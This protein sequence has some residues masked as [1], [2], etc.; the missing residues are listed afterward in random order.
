MPAIQYRA[1]R[2]HFTSLGC[3]LIFTL[4]RISLAHAAQSSC[5]VYNFAD[6]HAPCS[7]HDTS[8]EAAVNDVIACDGPY[9][10]PGSSDTLD[11]VDQDPR[12]AGQTFVVTVTFTAGPSCGVT[13]TGQ[14]TGSISAASGPACP[15]Q[16]YYVSTEPP[17]TPQCGCKASGEPVDG[18]HDP[19]NPAT[20]DVFETEDD[21]VVT[22]P[23]GLRFQRLY[24]S[25]VRGTSDL[26]P[27]WRH[28]YS[29]SLHFLTGPQYIPYPPGGDTLFPVCDLGSRVY[30]GV[31][32]DSELRACM[33]D[34]EC[35]M[36]RFCLRAAV[37][38]RNGGFTAGSLERGL[39]PDRR[40]DDGSRCGSR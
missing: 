23:G 30:F 3:L 12:V 6:P 22:G 8:A 21:V 34:C 10:C 24:D 16:Q 37:G 36:D 25:A 7:A 2:K 18:V 31:R 11:S 33:G 1:W 20:G 32:R 40:S 26:G 5:L 17:A 28:S 19:I 9:F 38:W 29:R 15:T 4:L 35:V 13:A 14:G 39:L 27:A